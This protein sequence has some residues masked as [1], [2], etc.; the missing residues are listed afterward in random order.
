MSSIKYL[1][2]YNIKLYIKNKFIDQLI[3]TIQ[4]KQNLTHIL[5]DE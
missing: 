4:F 3:N 5:K 2:F 1:N